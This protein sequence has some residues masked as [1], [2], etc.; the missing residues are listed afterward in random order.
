MIV[1]NTGRR[2]RAKVTIDYYFLIERFHASALPT[3]RIC[4]THVKGLFG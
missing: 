4:Q 2:I 3:I 1:T